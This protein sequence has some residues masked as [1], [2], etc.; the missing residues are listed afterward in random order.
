MYPISNTGKGK[1]L[2]ARKTCPVNRNGGCHHAC[3][4]HF[5]PLATVYFVA[6]IEF[7]E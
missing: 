4:R 1:V 6:Q 2:H 5:A 7:L 3:Q